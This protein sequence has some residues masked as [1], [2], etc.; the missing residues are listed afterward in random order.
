MAIICRKNA[1]N[2]LEISQKEK[3]KY[4]TVPRICG[5]E[6]KPTKGKEKVKISKLTAKLKHIARGGGWHQGRVSTRD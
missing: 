3:A 1:K 4:W 6:G 2:L 5:I